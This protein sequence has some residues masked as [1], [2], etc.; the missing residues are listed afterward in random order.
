MQPGK[1]FY[2]HSKVG[3][4]VGTEDWVLTTWKDGDKDVL[5]VEHK[6]VDD[7]QQQWFWNEKNGSIHNV[8]QPSLYVDMYA[9]NNG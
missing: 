1:W 3:E 7:R 9:G 4:D 5:G 8:A 2:L 6:V